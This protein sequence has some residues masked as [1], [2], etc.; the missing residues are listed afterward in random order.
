M[1]IQTGAGDDQVTIRE[2]GLTAYG[3]ANFTL[4]TGA[5]DDTLT[6]LSRPSRRRY[7]DK[8]LPVGDFGDTPAGSPLPDDAHYD[9]IT[10]VF[11][12]DGGAGTNTL[13]AV[14]DTDWTLGAT[15]LRNGSGGILV[16]AHVAN[17]RLTGGAGNNVIVV[18]D[19]AGELSLD[20]AGG[21]D[22]YTVDAGAVNGVT[23]A[24]SGTDGVD[25]LNIIGS[26]R[27]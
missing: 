16:L 3:L 24:D 14:A 27:G 20:G 17:A 6:L 9:P 23:V 26:S 2:N 5:G 18:T 10:G 4:S 15:S 13:T 8:Y 21:S 11:T 19:W 7:A 1:S 22:Q 25:Q 12:F